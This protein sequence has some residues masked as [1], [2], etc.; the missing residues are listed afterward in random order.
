MNTPYCILERSAMSEKV[1]VTTMV[2]EV[3]RRLRNMSPYVL[4][5]EVNEELGRFAEK[6]KRSGYGEKTRKMVIVAG[7]KGYDRMKREDEA[8]IRKLYRKHEDGE[9]MRW[10]KKLGGKSSWF[11]GREG[12]EQSGEEATVQKIVGNMVKKHGKNGRGIPLKDFERKKKKERD[13][14][15]GGKKEGGIGE[16]TCSSDLRGVYAGWGTPKTPATGG[17]QL[18]ENTR[19]TKSEVR[20]ARRQEHSISPLQLQPLVKE[21]LWEILPNM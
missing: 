12:K 6:M 8:G 11:K 2:Q 3:I 16:R 17:G 5:E 13:S 1:K 4:K 21:A 18:G 19:N 9:K 7:K 10:A 15:N 14:T 20:G